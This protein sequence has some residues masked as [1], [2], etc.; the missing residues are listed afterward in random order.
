MNRAF[1]GLTAA[2]ISLMLTGCSG[3]K[4][5]SASWG[6]IGRNTEESAGEAQSGDGEIVYQKDFGAYS[7]P[8][9]WVESSKHSTSDKFFYILE[10]AEDEAR[11]ENISVETGKN[12][13]S[14]NDHESFRRA[15]ANQLAMQVGD[16]G[17][18]ITGGG[19]STDEN[20]VYKFV[21]DM[22]D[23]SFATTQYYIVGDYK[24]VL[25]HETAAAGSEEADGAAEAIVNSF[26]WAE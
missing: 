9:G 14:E 20:V 16:T 21:I 24:Y 5:T 18:S 17:A 25:V 23:G 22:E 8:S 12:K 19:Y 15:I 10:G 3:V 4:G 6:V 7:V 11:P 26:V 2:V 1:W 13:Y